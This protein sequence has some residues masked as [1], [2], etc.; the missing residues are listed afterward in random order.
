VPDGPDR[1]ALNEALGG[2]YQI[3]REL[4]RGAF[5]T[6]YLARER[7][8]HRL[9]A[10]KV[11]HLERAASD[12]ERERF[13]REARMAAHRMGVRLALGA[14]ASHVA[15]LVMREGLGV[16]AIGA[17]VGVVAALAS[18][19]FVESLLYEVSARDPLV[20]TAV[21]ATLLTVAI[22]ATLVPTWRA[23]RVDP[24]VALRAE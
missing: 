5:A 9:V 23:M 4:G 20:F 18:A 21:V 7:V 3:V 2:S 15:G 13:T 17:A 6:V 10:I 14:Q 22:G 11:L 16:T 12:A 24:V 19:P 1:D 8:L